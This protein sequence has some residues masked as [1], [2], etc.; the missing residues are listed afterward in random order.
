MS[1]SQDRSTEQLPA[2][3]ELP[4]A[5]LPKSDLIMGIDLGTTFSCVAIVEDDF[6]KVIPSRKGLR[7]TPSIVALDEKSRLLV[8]EDARKQLL[9]NPTNTIYGA[10]RFIGRHFYSD[11]VSTLAKYFSYEIV[12]IGEMEVGAKIGGAI[13]SLP[14]V[15]AMVLNELRRNVCDYLK[16]NVWQAVISVPAYYS[17]NQREAVREAGRIAG[18]EVVR[19][20]NEPT[21]AALAYGMNKSFEKRILVYDLGGGTFD[22]SVMELYGDVFKVLA[23][24]GDTF[25]GG[26]DFDERIVEYILSEYERTQNDILQCDSVITQRLKDAAERA[27]IEL[28]AKSVATIDLP[29]ITISKGKFK[30]FRCEI[31]R[32]QLND[33]TGEFVDRT[34]EV[35][36]EVL[37]AAGMQ[38][39]SV[40]S[41]LLVGGQTRMPLVTDKV[42]RFFAKQ[43]TK[44]VH[45]DE[46]VACGAA[47]MGHSLG[48]QRSV[49][50]IDVLPMSIGGRQPS[51]AFKVLFPAN[52]TLPAEREIG[53]ATVHPGQDAIEVFLYQG[54]SPRAIDNEFLGAFVVTGFPK[55][56][57]GQVR[58]AV[59][60]SLNQESIL[61]VSARSLSTSLPMH[62]QMVARAPVS[63]ESAGL[64]PIGPPPPDAPAP[65]EPGSDQAKRKERL[66]SGLRGFIRRIK[67]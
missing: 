42:S 56:P 6:P 5:D 22:A 26:V 28:S 35:C 37:D 39:D 59:T 57:A 29:Y 12:P 18:I 46:V 53:V 40:D 36:M 13:Y 58:L 62:V 51:G 45:P 8:G 4:S 10:K 38:P 63:A 60:L 67:S 55:A 61:D 34:I 7:T 25:L 52:S 3:V 30:D 1:E 64:E 32:E 16:K 65:Q 15:S 31:T 44:G 24:G 27:K 23:T 66:F 9:I 20:I 2:V 17:E 50:L 48:S 41:V 33:L 21:A 19:I 11:E 54:E 47:L 43:P 49:R 14:Q